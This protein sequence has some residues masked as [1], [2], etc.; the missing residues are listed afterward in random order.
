MLVQDQDLFSR[1]ESFTKYART[2]SEKFGV[3][4]VLDGTEAHTDGKVI[5]LPN[6]GSLDEDELDFMYGILLHEV[7]HIRHSVFTEESFGRLKTEAHFIIAN[8]LEDGRIENKMMDEFNGA[9][10]IFTDLYNK[11]AANP[12][13]ME[14]CFGFKPED[15]SEFYALTAHLHYTLLDIP[16]K[17]TMEQ[18]IGKKGLKKLNGIKVLPEIDKLLAQAKID[19]DDDVFELSVKIYDLYFSGKTKDK[20]KVNQTQP[21]REV[22][23][24]SEK[25]IKSLQEE[26]KAKDE[27]LQPLRDKIK[28][29]R[30]ELKDTRA[31]RKP[32]DKKLD[33]I[34]HELE[35]NGGKLDLFNNE[36]YHKRQIEYAEETKDKLK[37]KIDSKDT[38]I[39]RSEKRQE[40]I[41]ERLDKAKD[42]LNSKK[43]RAT[44][45]EIEQMEKDIEAIEKVMAK[46]QKQGDN[47]SRIKKDYEERI[48]A[49]DKNSDWARE[50]IDKIHE[51][52]QK[53]TDTKDELKEHQKELYDER[54]PIGEKHEEIS[55]EMQ[56]IRDELKD[57]VTEFKKAQSKELLDSTEK[58]QQLQDLCDKMGLPA[59]VSPKFEPIPGWDEANDAQKTFDKTATAQKGQPI[60][61][62]GVGA[63]D[64]RDV[65]IM[66]DKGESELKAID[67]AEIF[68]KENSISRLESYNDTS[69]V[70]NTSNTPN[71]GNIKREGVNKHIPM[72]TTFDVVAKKTRSNSSK[73][74]K[75]KSENKGLIR[76]VKEIFRNRLRYNKKIRFKGDKEEGLL[77]TRTI[78]RMASDTGDDFYET[79]KALKVNQVACS[80][81]LDVSGSME[82]IENQEEMLK[83]IAM[84]LSEGMNESFIRHEIC[85][86]HAPVCDD[87]RA[88]GGAKVFNRTSNNLET[89]LYKGFT[90][91]KNTGLNNVEINCTDNS[92]G[93]SLLVIGGRLLRERARRKVLFLVADG[94]PY[95]SGSD[96]E[97]LD[98]DLQD[99]MVYLERKG[100]EIH[101]LSHNKEA[102]KMYGKRFFLIEKLEDVVKFCDERIHGGKR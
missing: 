15:M 44:K 60:V 53:I 68:K 89:V 33:K 18:V 46:A 83:G 16:I 39:E 79:P 91:R 94:R 7:G 2:I 99:A 84:L 101:V 29:L 8:A 24:E 56:E 97:L 37:K 72:T 12:N 62:G 31:T 48:K 23:E 50:Q 47:H 25:T 49:H 61:N 17:L 30:K 66:M 22:I 6:M 85:G 65:L 40:K 76:K 92:D 28:E 19:N 63:T 58:L 81:M 54:K 14:R 100:V 95:L 88:M 102:E 90:D 20:S 67:L 32:Y 4:V 74:L 77:D 64:I 45:E 75:L 27:K 57:L 98:K 52:Q 59:N 21:R 80:I 34:D 38:A 96:I 1:I 93:E 82:K 9:V 43:S 69:Q 41:G 51:K 26:L 10:D 35:K 87:I 5:T 71:N 3:A 13:F 73:L 86:F 55:D 11:F 36:D 42:K 78:W 70:K